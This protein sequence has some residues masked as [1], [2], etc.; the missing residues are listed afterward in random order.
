MPTT[1]SLSVATSAAK[2]LGLYVATSGNGS[3][4]ERMA[5][6]S[7]DE[8]IDYWKQ[9][10]AEVLHDMDYVLDTL[11]DAALPTSSRSRTFTFLK[12]EQSQREPI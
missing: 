3:S 7:V 9:S 12:S 5:A 2:D 10:F 8:F 11:G 4:A 6:L 1:S